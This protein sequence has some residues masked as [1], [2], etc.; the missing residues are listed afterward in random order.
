MPEIRQLPPSVINKIAAGEVIER[1]A[2]VVKELLENAVDSGAKRIDVLVENGGSQLIRV[3]DDGCGVS[4]DQ[5]PLTVASHATSKILELEEIGPVMPS[6]G[7]CSEVITLFCGRVDSEGVG[8]LHGL[9]GEH[10]DI[11][12]F[13]V[14]AEDALADLKRGTYLNANAVITLQWLALNRD[15]LR[16]LWAD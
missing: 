15:R 16:A 7:G 10:E 1:P 11:R 13:V 2:S 14:P 5:L 8:G 12:A 3:S 9:D 6:P 4:S